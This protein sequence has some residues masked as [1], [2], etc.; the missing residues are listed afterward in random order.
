MRLNHPRT[1]IFFLPAALAGILLGVVL[2]SSHMRMIQAEP[3]S[4]SSTRA[5]SGSSEAAAVVSSSGDFQILPAAGEE[6]QDSANVNQNNDIHNDNHSYYYDH[7][8]ALTEWVRNTP[9]GYLHPSVE[10]RRAAASRVAAAASSS[11]T[12]SS[13]SSTSPAPH[14]YSVFATHS[15]AVGE[16]LMRIPR[17]M[18]LD[19]GMPQIG[20]RVIATFADPPEDDSTDEEEETP[21]PQPG[22][23]YPGR[24]TNIHS[25]GT[26]DVLCDTDDEP[27]TH[28]ES[29]QVRHEESPVNCATVR[30][31]AN[32][33]RQSGD[34]ATNTTNSTASSASSLPYEPYA[35]YL[36]SLPKGQLPVAWSS[37]GQSLLR[38]LL[39][40]KG[41]RDDDEN[42]D[43][44]DENAALPPDG[45]EGWLK[46]D[47]YPRCLGRRA[48][49]RQPLQ[50]D[51]DDLYWDEI[52]YLLVTQRSW[53]ELLIPV[54]DMLSHRNGKWLNTDNVPLRLD[55][56]DD[57][58]DNN[59]DDKDNRD[60][61]VFAR[62]DIA[63]GEELY[64]S[65]NMCR[66]CDGRA[67]HYGTPEILRDYG[68]VEDYPRRFVFA[69]HDVSFDVDLIYD[70]T[71]G[72][73]TDRV[74]VEWTDSIPN[75]PSLDFLRDQHQRLLDW[76]RDV[77]SN[78]ADDPKKPT[79]RSTVP[80]HEWEVIVQYAEALI[81]A[82]GAAVSS[83]ED[84]SDGTDACVF[85]SPTCS[86]R[87]YPLLRPSGEES[88]THFRPVTCD[89]HKEFSY[90]KW[91]NVAEF[92]TPYQEMAFDIN[93]TMDNDMCFDL[94]SVVQMCASY[95]P[96]YHEMFVHYPA[97]FVPDV[98]RIIF[99]GGGDSMLLHEALKYPS[100]ELV[101]GLEL[102]QAVVRNSFRFFGTQPHWDNEKVEWWFG[103]ATKSLLVLP[104][105]Y[106]GSFDLVL[107]D[108][109]ETVMALSVTDKLD[110]MEALKLL[111][112]P[113]G[114]ILVQN[115]YDHFLEQSRL[116]R[117][118]LT[119]HYYGVPVVCS[120]SLVLASNGV[121][122]LRGPVKHHEI[123][124][125]FPLLKEDDVRYEIIRDYQRNATNGR[126]LDDASC[127]STTTSE[128]AS[129]P[130]SQVRSPGV[131]MIIEAEQVAVDLEKTEALQKLLE[132]AFRQSGLTPVTSM[133][134]SSTMTKKTSIGGDLRTLTF[135]LE[136]G[137]A[138]ARAFPKHAYL[139]LDVHLW[140]RQDRHDAT[141]RALRDVVGS[142]ATATSA[143][144]I[145]AGGMFGTEGWSVDAAKLGP[146]LEDDACSSGTSKHSGGAKQAA[147]TPAAKATKEGLEERALKESLDILR[148][149]RV[150][151][152]VLCGSH[153]KECQSVKWLKAQD[154][155]AKN[156][157]PIVACKSL[158]TLG[159]DPNPEENDRMA[160]CEAEIVNLLQQ[161][162]TDTKIR[163]IVV[164]AS[165]TYP[166]ARI[167]TRILKTED[168]KKAF[169]AK[170]LF[171]QATVTD[172]ADWRKSF[173]DTFRKGLF[174]DDPVYRAEVHFN[175]TVAGVDDFR[176]AVASSGSRFFPKQVSQFVER[177]EQSTGLTAI[178]ESIRAGNFQYEA[179]F[180]AEGSFSHDS[181]DLTDQRKQWKEQLPIGL[182]TVFQMERLVG[183]DELS[184]QRLKNALTKSVSLI[185]SHDRA[186]MVELEQGRV[187]DGCVVSQLWSDGNVV[188]L[189]DGRNHVDINLFT[190]GGESVSEKFQEHFLARVASLKTMLRDQFPRG[191]GRVVNYPRP[192]G[193]PH[194]MT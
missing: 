121:D 135:L 76:H 33:L 10:L 127:P 153:V 163:V 104:K 130:I 31:L 3:S 124:T 8:R 167:V 193:D 19:P 24:V 75:G 46:H 117:D 154:S 103:D 162:T 7:G 68:F 37:H 148:V 61:V 56:D 139:A 49:P 99:I 149:G 145:V 82:V 142:H 26:Y 122:F 155:K 38:Q 134:S 125:L 194:W 23:D 180:V 181:Y 116:F 119:I 174:G 5:S 55:D 97:R 62:R 11:S 40:T 77:V 184:C 107:V 191:I 189:W 45:W 39:G 91:E 190:L 80:Q 74:S 94:D 169:V 86:Q 72:F 118:A 172:V 141:R 160:K 69:E 151:V 138:V 173:V 42:D 89:W 63:A 186:T 111:V 123:D 58:D 34:A 90:D 157:I 81:T 170:D 158:E 106:F 18:V 98:K 87:L 110:V 159:S 59:N 161:S 88:W 156:V 114:G 12:S 171:V 47:Y 137:Y 112:H 9:G 187:G 27:E 95:R 150:S 54:F 136:E 168:H 146:P 51:I 128:G 32:A 182:Q 192:K 50:P 52:A 188:L 93:P 101:V 144:R 25:D 36:R 57:D 177:M 143:F 1:G 176:V 178:I 48:M 165:A 29:D 131:V 16:V 22:G 120:Q 84:G 92:K 13:S 4:S 96:H 147:K 183:E 78:N 17:T 133:V 185:G 14:Y 83:V 108:L 152:A 41:D 102:D 43:D 140:S 115:E 20:D 28:I 60:V 21:Q 175:G 44:D 30:L 129:S 67:R 53:D 15:I 132:S 105:E 126:Q 73:P 71:T 166:L 6:Q 2:P 70:P 66:D 179:D 113:T 100:L 164:D 65:Y 109:S 79:L 35:Q 85:G 64:T